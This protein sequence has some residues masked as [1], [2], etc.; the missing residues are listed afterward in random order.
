MRMTWQTFIETI[1]QRCMRARDSRPARD[2]NPYAMTNET[3][4]MVP[5][6]PAT[7]G[8]TIC[9]GALIYTGF[10]AVNLQ[11]A[12]LPNTAPRSR[13]FTGGENSAPG[14]RAMAWTS[15]GPRR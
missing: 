3:A 8:D 14:Q 11:L 12:I 5:S 15:S 9:G 7:R 2:A 6:L 1:W 4:S 13:S 10:P